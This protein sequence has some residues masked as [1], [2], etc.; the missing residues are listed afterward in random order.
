MTISNDGFNITWNPPFYTAVNFSEP[1]IMYCIE[2]NTTLC[3]PRQLVFMCE[4][5]TAD[6][7][8]VPEL[9]RCLTLSIGIRASNK[10]G[11]TTATVLTL[12]N[13]CLSRTVYLKGKVSN[14]VKF[15][16]VL[17]CY[18]TIVAKVSDFMAFRFFPSKHSNKKALRLKGIWCKNYISPQSKFW[19]AWIYSWCSN[20]YITSLYVVDTP[21]LTKH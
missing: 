12:K 8:Y 18:Y 19:F 17:I 20:S 6:F 9:Y 3:F 4:L 1:D 13:T 14:E 15:V 5:A 10:V 21:H 11:N 16:P 7:F 2:I